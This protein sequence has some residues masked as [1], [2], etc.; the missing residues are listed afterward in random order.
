MSSRSENVRSSSESGNKVRYEYVDCVKGLSILC[1]TFL[2]FEKGVIPGW[3]NVWIGLFMITAFYFTS[4]WVFGLKSRVEGPRELWSKRLIQLGVPYLWFGV[5]ILVF[6]LIWWACGMMTIH[7]LGREVYK[8]V[9]LRGLGT[10]WFLPVLFLGELIFSWLR[11]SRRP[12]LYGSIMFVVTYIVSYL[13]YYDWRPMLEGNTLY[14]MIDSPIRPIVMALTAWPV[15]AI[16]Y[17]MSCRWAHRLHSLNRWICGA[18][19]IGLLIVSIWF[20]I[21]PPFNFYYLNNVL[22][23][24]FPVLGFIGVFIL[25]TGSPIERFF[26]YWGRNSLI[27]MCTHFSITM[28]LLMAFDIYMLHHKDFSGWRTIIYFAV[29]VFL[30]YPI[31]WLINKRFSFMLGKKK[32]ISNEV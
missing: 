13:Y 32:K 19:G 26:A 7:T 18:G 14:Q 30:T 10:L 28:E 20:V 8:Y 6:D 3:L 11:S 25:M 31:V 9:T 24:L 23:T 12:W 22:A 5:L 29:C 4:G 2:H 16:G 27:L 21:S 15:I 1:I 17:F